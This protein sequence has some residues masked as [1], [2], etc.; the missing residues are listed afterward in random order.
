[1]G[2]VTESKGIVNYVII[3]RD[4]L[5]GLREQSKL[6]H[7]YNNLVMLSRFRKPLVDYSG[8]RAIR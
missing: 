8:I 2:V 4:R 7:T 5:G 1:M 3:F 6:N